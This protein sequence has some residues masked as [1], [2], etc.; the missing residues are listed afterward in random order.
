MGANI[1]TGTKVRLLLE[2]FSDRRRLH[3]LDH[4]RYGDEGV[5]S[6]PSRA[7]DMAR[8]YVIVHFGQ[9]GHDHRLLEDEFAVIDGSS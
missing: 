6:L 2:R 5:V 9:C 4:A 8:L 3:L 7:P 1:E